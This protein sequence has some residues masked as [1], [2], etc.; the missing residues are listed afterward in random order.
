MA[1]L[2]VEPELVEEAVAAAVAGLPPD[3][4]RAECPLQAVQ[5]GRTR[6]L[7]LDDVRAWARGWWRRKTGGAPANDEISD[8]ARTWIDEAL[9]EAGEG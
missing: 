2:G 4:F 3:R 7:P 5:V 9:G 1:A 6:L 8:D